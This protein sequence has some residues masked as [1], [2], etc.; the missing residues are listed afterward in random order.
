LF[1]DVNLENDSKLQ[2]HEDMIAAKR[3]GAQ[4]LEST[5]NDYS[6]I[7]KRQIERE[8]YQRLQSSKSVHL[9][10]SVPTKDDSQSPGPN[11]IASA[12][13]QAVLSKPLRDNFKDSKMRTEVLCDLSE[14]FKY[15]EYKTTTP[16]KNTQCDNQK[17]SH[18][19]DNTLNGLSNSVFLNNSRSQEAN[20]QS[21]TNETA[22]QPHE[23]NQLK[24]YIH[25]LE[26]KLAVLR[27]DLMDN[28]L[29][30]NK[31]SSS[32]TSNIS[33]N[34]DRANRNDSS[35]ESVNSI[36]E[37]GHEYL[38]FK[39]Q[40]RKSDK[41]FFEP[42][43]NCLKLISKPEHCFMTPNLSP[44]STFAESTNDS[45]DNASSD[46]LK[47]SLH[48]GLDSL[49]DKVKVVQANLVG[50]GPIHG[51]SNLSVDKEESS[52][53]TILRNGQAFLSVKKGLEHSIA[54]K[55]NPIDSAQNGN[56]LNG[57]LI[58]REKDIVDE[59][60][61][62]RCKTD[63]NSKIRTNSSD[64]DMRFSLVH[65]ADV[66]DGQP[67][68][69]APPQHTLNHTKSSLIVAHENQ[70]SD[71]TETCKQELNLLACM[72]DAKMVT[73]LSWVFF[74]VLDRFHCFVL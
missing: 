58:E 23:P 72:K 45:G 24:N 42:H 44:A 59:Q 61:Q 73:V 50:S 35:S 31:S 65:N 68:T 16:T 4:L 3:D 26:K 60:L 67:L 62:N 63:L 46:A 30:D 37:N 28:T 9:L 12:S 20:N 74:S 17:S 33:G 70:L 13:R 64:K 71:V 11:T 29:T 34:A 55:Y 19:F 49:Y 43:K 54:V 14:N 6:V 39:R 15:Y 25:S 51:N 27:V 40:I 21:A 5:K 41:L 36:N 18:N 1:D 38:N 53:R 69:N 2:K 66:N 47:V 56:K 52:K 10:C 7:N 32:S 22:S 57:V 8:D 48:Q